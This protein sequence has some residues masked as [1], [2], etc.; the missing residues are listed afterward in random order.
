MCV[1]VCEQCLQFLV[2]CC[3]G[4][5]VLDG[6]R[7]QAAN[8]EG[9]PPTLLHLALMG[10]SV[11]GAGGKGEEESRVKVLRALLAFVDGEDLNAKDS[12]GA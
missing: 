5:K 10:P 1:Y 4:K 12:Q 6:L 7:P 9:L 8:E 2:D 3:R 11:G